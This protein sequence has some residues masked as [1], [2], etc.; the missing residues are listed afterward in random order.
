MTASL[1]GALVISVL[2]GVAVSAAFIVW[3]RRQTAEEWIVHRRSFRRAEQAGHRGPRWAPVLMGARSGES[4][5]EIRV[6]PD[7]DLLILRLAGAGAP[8]STE[9]AW[10]RL[11][12]LAGAGALGGLTIVTILA[13]A[14]GATGLAFAAPVVGLV[15]AAVTPGAQI[16]LWRLKAQQVRSA[17]RKDLPRV[18]MGAR[19]LLDGGAATAEGALAAAVG[20][21]ADPAAELFREALRL[22]EVRRIELEAAMDEVGDR[23]AITELHRLPDSFRVGQR[24]GTGMSAL[25]VDFAQAARGSWHAHYRER[26]TRA[27][28]VMTVPA[29]I[30]FV[31][32]LLVLVMFL[33]FTPLMGTLSRL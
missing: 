27:P 7:A 18:L 23:Y 3:P 2:S 25:L 20:T 17:I 15:A 12:W 16:I 8:K 22:K 10:R 1:I 9:E 13:F 29:L 4:R 30:F 24:Y 21:Y 5:T 28:V 26:I 6:V 33:V 11:F 19:V 31:L 32:P 14:A